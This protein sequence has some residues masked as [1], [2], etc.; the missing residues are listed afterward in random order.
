MRPQIQCPVQGAN[1][2]TQRVPV[3]VCAFNNL[4]TKQTYTPL[5]PALRRQRQVDFCDYETSLVYRVSLQGYTEK[6]CL[7]KRKKKPD[8]QNPKT[9][10]QTDRL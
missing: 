2:Q 3:F 5:I 10:K 6:P 4:K 1:K 8:S 9:N 7:E